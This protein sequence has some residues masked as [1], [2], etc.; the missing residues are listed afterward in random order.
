MTNQLH[1]IFT[2]GPPKPLSI[3]DEI[4][5]LVEQAEYADEAGHPV[6]ALLLLGTAK[7]RLVEYLAG[8]AN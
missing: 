5:D 3:Y 1:Q 8:A 2:P 7:N 6:E 4:I